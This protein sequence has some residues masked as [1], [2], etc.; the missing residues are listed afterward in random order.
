MAW[1]RSARTLAAR[2]RHIVWKL[3]PPFL[4]GSLLGAAIGGRVVVALPAD[5]VQI[6]V[7]LFVLW[8]VFVSPPL[9]MHKLAWLTGAISSFPTMFFGATGPFVVAYLKSLGLER[10]GL[11]ATHATLMTLQHLLKSLVF[12]VLGFAFAPWAARIGAMIAAGF[13][14]TLAGRAVLARIEVEPSDPGALRQG[15]PPVD[16]TGATDPGQ[17]AA[18]PVLDPLRTAV[19]G[20]DELRGRRSAARHATRFSAN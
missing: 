15:R 3:V 12:D 6:A 1:F 20:A 13:L 9:A 11:V 16:P 7:G 14:V 2:R 4:I 18:D 17:P 10:H 8:S 19:D 5:A